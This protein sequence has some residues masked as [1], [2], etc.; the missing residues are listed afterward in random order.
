MS[1]SVFNIPDITPTVAGRDV[2]RVFALRRRVP[3]YCQQAVQHAGWFAVVPQIMARGGEEARFRDIGPVG[4]LL[5]VGQRLRRA[6][7]FGDVPEGDDHAFDAA[8]LVRYGRIGRLYQI[9][10]RVETSFS[11]GV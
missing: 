3:C 5:G 8:V 6:F 11:I 10:F 7:V 2:S 9:P 1:S 4:D